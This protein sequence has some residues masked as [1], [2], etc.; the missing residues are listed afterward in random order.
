MILKGGGKTRHWAGRRSQ[1]LVH[2][3]NKEMGRGGG[4]W[5]PLA[6]G[7]NYQIDIERVVDTAGQLPGVQL[8]RLFGGST[9]PKFTI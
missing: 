2:F 9:I 6:Q 8:D 4:Y 1:C 3:L 5:V 7:E